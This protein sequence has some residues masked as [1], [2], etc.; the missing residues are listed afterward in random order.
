MNTDNLCQTGR[1][2]QNQQDKCH[3]RFIDR[4][5]IGIHLSHLFQKWTH[6]QKHDCNIRYSQSHR[7]ESTGKATCL[8]NSNNN[9]QQTPCSHIIISCRSNR[10]SPQRSFGHISFLND[11]RQHGESGNTHGDA[12]KQGKRQKGSMIGS[13]R[14]V[15]PVRRQNTQ[16]ERY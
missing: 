13:I 12:Y 15:N 11:T 3:K 2:N 4:L 5:L 14:F 9:S 7:I 10:K 16:K 1:N 6:N 8:W